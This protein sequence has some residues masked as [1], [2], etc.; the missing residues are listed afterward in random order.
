MD[1]LA[2]LNQLSL[3]LYEEGE[4]KD[5]ATT[6]QFKH[7]DFTDLAVD[8]SKYREGYAP[9]VRDALIGLVGRPAG[10]LDAVDV[11]AGTGIW[12]RT[13]ADGGFRSVTAVEPNDN[14]RA[15]GTTDSAAYAISWRAGRGERTG[16]ESESADLVSM[17][18]SFHW[19]DFA[20]G[21]EEFRRL[22]RP[23]G[24]F[25]A[26]YNPRL[27]DVNPV[28]VDIEAELNRLMGD[29]KRVTSAHP[30]M[31]KE[32]TDRFAAHPQFDDVVVIE[33]RHTVEQSVSHYLGIWRSVND[34]RVQLGDAAFDGFLDFIQKRLAGADKLDVTYLTRAVAARAKK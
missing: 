3:E 1:F 29:K 14:M 20:A 7:G 5:M 2:D 26:L 4:T 13:L 25:T 17:A 22:L 30:Q 31:I 6:T 33:G 12:T 15:A 24:W 9:S 34:V 21:T 32:L 8:Y 27:I 19:V 10:S 23:G 18:S 11:G 28:L 16:L